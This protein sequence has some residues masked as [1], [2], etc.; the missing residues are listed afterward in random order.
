MQNEAETQN[1]V[2][3]QNGQTDGGEGKSRTEENAQNVKDFGMSDMENSRGNIHC[4]TIVGQVEGHMLLPSQNKST[5][6]EHVIPLLVSVEQDE[7]IDG[8]L[9]VRLSD[10]A[11][12]P[13]W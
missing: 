11:I 9:V 5:K 3:P 6:Y 4:L 7:K 12:F 8:L 1:N 2:M 13:T 10:T